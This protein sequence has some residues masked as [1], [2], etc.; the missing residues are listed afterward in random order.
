MAGY[1]GYSKSNNAVQAERE[2]KKT[3]SKLAAWIRRRGHLYK[4]C[5]AADVAATMKPCEWHHTSKFYNVTNY[6]DPRDL[7]GLEV[8]RALAAR[9]ADKA[10]R[11]NERNERAKERH[12]RRVGR[13]LKPQLRRF[14]RP[15]KAFFVATLHSHSGW[16]GSLLGR[17]PGRKIGEP[18]RLEELSSA[19]RAAAYRQSE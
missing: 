8:R 19:P 14:Q 15:E 13:N 10:G 1:D 4:G 7:M 5:T 3:A 16:L 6:Y 12:R 18:L 2:G 11:E 17:M 9:I